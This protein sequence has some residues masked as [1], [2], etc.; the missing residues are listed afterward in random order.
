MPKRHARLTQIVALLSVAMVAVAPAISQARGSVRIQ[1]TDGKVEIYRDVHLNLNGN[2]LRIT[3]ADGVG[4]LIVSQAA[5]SLVNGMQ[6]C[7]PYA[8]I[9]RQH[10]DH[11]IMFDHGAIYLNTSG[12]SHQ[13]PRSS[14]VVPANGVLA[15]LK[16]RR[17]TYIS[18]NGELDGV[19]K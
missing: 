3:T 14:K 18:I 7:L 10:G 19:S 17:G 4:T 9:L 11:T 8:L 15:L 2:K 12:E 6:R 13:L 16:T 1:H 5:C